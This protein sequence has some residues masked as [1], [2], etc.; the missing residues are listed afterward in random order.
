M[1]KYSPVIAVRMVGLGFEGKKPGQP[2]LS[3]KRLTQAR[4]PGIAILVTRLI[5]LLWQ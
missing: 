5:R 3:Y 4:A 2:G 1:V